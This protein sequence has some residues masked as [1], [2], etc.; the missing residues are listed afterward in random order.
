MAWSK[1]ILLLLF[2]QTLSDF[3]IQLGKYDSMFYRSLRFQHWE[4]KQLLGYAFKS[5]FVSSSLLSC[6][7]QCLR[8][9]WC[10]STSFKSSSS[11]TDDEGTRELNKHVVFVVKKTATLMTGRNLLFQCFYWEF[12]CCIMIFELSSAYCSLF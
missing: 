3:V 2:V 4:N 8:N 7:Q 12:Q 9:Q 11:K 6:S 1:T 5:G 10:S